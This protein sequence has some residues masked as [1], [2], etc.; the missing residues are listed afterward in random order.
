MINKFLNILFPTSCKI[1]KKPST[2]HRTAP[3]CSECWEEALPYK[4]P[5]CLKCGVPIAS[6]FASTCGGCLKDEPP[7]DHARSF[8]LHS[9]TLKEAVNLLKFHGIKRLSK[10]L[11]EKI[12]GMDLPNVD[13]LMPVP[14]HEKRMRQRE[15]NQSALIGKHVAKHLG[16]PIIVNSLLRKRDTIPQVGL[17][18]KERRKNIRNAFSVNK[19]GLIKGKRVMLVDDVFTTGATV[20]ECSKVLKRA[21]ADGVFVIT[22]THGVLDGR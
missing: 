20:R 4:G 13:L 11:S 6:E 19:T 22:L 9:S 12:N 16:V 5:A 17:S 15:F 21:G 3:I 10:P 14:L 8:G 2:S 1:C 7:F 18:A